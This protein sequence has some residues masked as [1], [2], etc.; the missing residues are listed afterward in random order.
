MRLLMPLAGL[1]GIEVEEITERVRAMAIIYA[2]IGLF[3]L[4]GLGFLLAAGFMLVAA[5][6][7]PL[8]AALIFA[9]AFLLLALAVYLGARI[10]ERRHKRQLVDRRRASETGTLLATAAVT[11]LPVMLKAPLP[12]KLGLPLAGL[13]ALALMRDDDADED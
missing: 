2:L 4:L 12:V 1:F 8:Y 10:G 11:A 5:R 7:G 13:V 6:L 3:L 9:G